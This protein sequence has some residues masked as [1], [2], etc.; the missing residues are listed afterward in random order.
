MQTEVNRNRL[1]AAND[2]SLRHWELI[3]F[4]MSDLAEPFFDR[5][6][7]GRVVNLAG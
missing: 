2:L 3:G 5:C 7:E 1:A 4:E 6:A